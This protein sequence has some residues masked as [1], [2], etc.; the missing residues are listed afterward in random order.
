M[1]FISHVNRYMRI[2]YLDNIRST[3]VILVVFYHVFFIFNSVIPELS[4]GC[5][6]KLQYQDIILYIFCILGS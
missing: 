1:I 3:T 2:L 6:N 4:V 5:F